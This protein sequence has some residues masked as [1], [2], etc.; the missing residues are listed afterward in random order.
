MTDAL[1]KHDPTIFNGQDYWRE[2]LAVHLSFAEMATMQR[3]AKQQAFL[4]AL[5]ELGTVRAA[6]RVASCCQWIIF[7]WAKKDPDFKMA[8]KIA[9]DQGQAVKDIELISIMR[10]GGKDRVPAIREMNRR[11]ERMEDMEAGQHS[12]YIEA[13]YRPVPIRATRPEPLQLTKGEET[14]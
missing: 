1:T 8:Y 3:D 11:E 4:A 7:E 10:E 5:A 9:L 6:C 2:T 14:G 12:P 13:E